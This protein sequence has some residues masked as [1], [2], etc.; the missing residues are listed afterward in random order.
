MPLTGE[1]KGGGDKIDM[2]SAA[3]LLT[4]PFIPS[5]QEDELLDRLLCLL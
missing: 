5:R 3:Y 2:E 1:G 4:L